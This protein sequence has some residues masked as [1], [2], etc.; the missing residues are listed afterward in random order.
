MSTPRRFNWFYVAYLAI[1]LSIIL[2]LTGI[3]GWGW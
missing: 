1:A 2:G 3:R